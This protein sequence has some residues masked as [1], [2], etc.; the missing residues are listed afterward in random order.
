M[1]SSGKPRY[2]PEVLIEMKESAIRVNSKATIFSVS[3]IKERSSEIKIN[4]NK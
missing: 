1:Y 3:S 4:I 2:F